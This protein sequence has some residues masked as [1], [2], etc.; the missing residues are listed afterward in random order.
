MSFQLCGRLLHA[1]SASLDA[2]ARD[3]LRYS[4]FISRCSA[5]RSGL[6]LLNELGQLGTDQEALLRARA[7]IPNALQLCCLCICSRSH[8]QCSKLFVDVLEPRLEIIGRSLDE[9]F[10]LFKTFQSNIRFAT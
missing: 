1:G 10:V 7:L 4:V 9:V 6:E 3:L 2:V 8:Y 5:C